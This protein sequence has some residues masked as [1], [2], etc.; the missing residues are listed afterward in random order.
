MG[1]WGG[2]L[3]AMG[4]YLEH[5]GCNW[6]ARGS[7]W[8]PGVAFESR[9]GS[10]WKPLEVHLGTLGILLVA[11]GVH[12]DAREIRLGALGVRLGTLG[13]VWVPGA[14]IWVPRGSPGAHVLMHKGCVLLHRCCI[15]CIWAKW[16]I[17]LG[18]GGPGGTRGTPRI[19]R[20]NVFQANLSVL[21]R[22]NN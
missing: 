18:L 11:R 12:L 1:A 22:T 7:I 15:S 14:T 8:V 16:W 2:H 10:I 6:L 3:V 9:G 19:S 20:L 21:G 5:K 13:S 17:G 4:L